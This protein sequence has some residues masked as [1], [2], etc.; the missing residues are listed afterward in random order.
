MTAPPPQ[1]PVTVL[2]FDFGPARIGVAVGDTLLRSARALETIDDPRSDVRLARIAALVGAWQPAT[3]V[4]GVPVHADG[5]E[6]ALTARAR[7]FARQLGGRFRLPVAE[8]DERYTTQAAAG[9]LAARRSGRAGRA[10]RDAVAA[11]L[12]L[13]GWLDEQP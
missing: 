2:A 13:Q 7:R 10:Q 3:L 4:V 9:V 12:I 11:Q 5:T 1:A 8:A 6:H